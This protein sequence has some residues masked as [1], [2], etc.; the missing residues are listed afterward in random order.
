MHTRTWSIGR[1]VLSITVLAIVGCGSK[2]STNTPALT[3]HQKDSLA[4]RNILDANGLHSTEV[5]GGV[6]IPD[7]INGTRVG[8]LNL[9]NK[10]ISVVSKDIGQLAALTALR[11]DSNAITSLPPE[12]GNCAALRLLSVAK[13]LLTGLPA[14][15]GKLQAL[16]NLNVSQNSITVLP[17]S[18]GDIPNLQ[19][20]RLNAN[21]LTTL[22]DS[23]MLCLNIGYLLVD[24]NK[25]CTG[26]VSASL[27][28]WLDLYAPGWETTQVCN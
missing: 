12:I 7:N 24:N 21:Q 19:T 27:K 14:E 23:I 9:Q 17:G 15:I 5:F 26:T 11:L 22:P 16:T 28:A 1:V 8:E 3:D 4:V 20:V 10:S 6:A 2:G 13:N 18:I 25:L